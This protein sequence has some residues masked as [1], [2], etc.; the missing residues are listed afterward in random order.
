MSSGTQSSNPAGSDPLA[1]AA[2]PRQD[3]GGMV[4]EPGAGGAYSPG[5]EAGGQAAPAPSGTLGL[6]DVPAGIPGV[7]FELDGEPVEA[8]P[9]ETL[10]AVAQRRGTHIPHLCHKPAPG[11]RP[12]GNCRACMV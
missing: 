5:A 1:P 11:Y 4:G 9:G 3:A 10:W 8:R 6:R 7:V 2:A 12:D